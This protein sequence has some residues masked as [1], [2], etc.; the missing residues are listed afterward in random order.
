MRVYEY[1]A[2]VRVPT[3]A[4]ALVA[5]RLVCRGLNGLYELALV[6]RVRG[7]DGYIVAHYAIFNEF[8]L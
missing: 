3:L 2:R 7:L 8:T 6:L 1:T 4:A 5:C